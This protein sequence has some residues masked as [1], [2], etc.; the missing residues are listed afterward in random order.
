MTSFADSQNRRAVESHSTFRTVC[1]ELICYTGWAISKILQN[2]LVSL[3]CFYLL[4][5]Q[6]YKYMT[7]NPRFLHLETLDLCDA[8]IE[9]RGLS[10]DCWLTFKWYCT[11]T[12]SNILNSSIQCIEVNTKLNTSHQLGAN[13]LQQ[14]ILGI[15]KPKACCYLN[16]VGH[17]SWVGTS[18]IID[19]R[20]ME[21]K[22]LLCQLIV[23]LVIKN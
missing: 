13:G 17:F 2:S 11:W 22:W 5:K 12:A 3:P 19:I 15:Y 16:I 10:R 6:C 7:L 4:Y 1:D 9:F 20:G 21:S 18:N 23:P 14:I 8:R